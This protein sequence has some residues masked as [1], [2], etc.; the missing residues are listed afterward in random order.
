MMIG[1]VTAP[2]EKQVM[3]I[4][5]IVNIYPTSCPKAPVVVLAILPIAPTVLV[6]LLFRMTDNIRETIPVK[7]ALVYLPKIKL[8]RIL[9]HAR[10]ISKFS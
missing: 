10:K 6:D 8:L 9:D 3:T 5:Q 4:S 1:M 7:G 2:F